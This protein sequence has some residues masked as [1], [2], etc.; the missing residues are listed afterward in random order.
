[1]WSSISVFIACVKDCCFRIIKIQRVGGE[2]TRRPSSIP[3]CLLN[4]SKGC[5]QIAPVLGAKRSVVTRCL[6]AFQASARAGSPIG[7][8]STAPTWASRRRGPFTAGTRW[9]KP[10]QVPRSLSTPT[11]LCSPPIRHISVAYWRLWLK[12]EVNSR[13]AE[14]DWPKEA[15]IE[16][17]M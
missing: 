6:A 4:S 1:M 16:W 11:L 7:C 13:R 3:L 17:Q 5:L 8:C 12:A 9:R 15:W 2:N 14:R 10:H